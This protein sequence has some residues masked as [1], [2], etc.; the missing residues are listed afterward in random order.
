MGVR[1]PCSVAEVPTNLKFDTVTDPLVTGDFIDE[2]FFVFIS[3]KVI[4]D[5]GVLMR[6]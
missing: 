1:L 5:L 4:E 2:P 3:T 6:K